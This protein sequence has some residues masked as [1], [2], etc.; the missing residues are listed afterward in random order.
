MKSRRKTWRHGGA[1]A[2]ALAAATDD[3]KLPDDDVVAKT[4]PVSFK[5][6]ILPELQRY[7]S[8]MRWRLDLTSYD[9]VKASAR[10]I[11]ILISTNQMPPPPF[12]PFSADF[13][14]TFKGWIVQDYPA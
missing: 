5:A 13:I 3:D 11:Y 10:K 7:L 9:D 1:P 6:D 2:V 4:T 14:S 12:D 8:Q